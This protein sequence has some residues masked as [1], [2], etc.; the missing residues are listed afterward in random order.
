MRQTRPHSLP[1]FSLPRIETRRKP[2]AAFIWPK[3]GS[4]MALGHH[5]EHEEGQVPL[6]QPLCRRGREQVRLQRRPRAAGL[7]AAQRITPP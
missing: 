3:T 1:A 7:H 2:L 5:L 6:G 4:T